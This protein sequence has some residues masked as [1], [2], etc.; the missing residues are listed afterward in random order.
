M[1][2][3]NLYEIFRC[4]NC[5][6]F[7]LLAILV[8]L[9]AFG[10]QLMAQEVNMKITIHVQDMEIRDVISRL[11]K[12]S[13]FHFV[14]EEKSLSDN[15]KI[16]LNF[17][18]KEFAVVLDEFCRQGSLRYEVK[19]NLILLSKKEQEKRLFPKKHEL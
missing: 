2:K 17:S 10:G 12:I 8:L 6:I 15:R 14:Y 5:T 3:K 11:Q 18:Q 7:H 1:E 19:R 16:S 9:T 13:G 4:R